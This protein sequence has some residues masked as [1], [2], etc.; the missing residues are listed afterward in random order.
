M[1][2]WLEQNG[3]SKP[4]DL[5]YAFSSYAEAAAA[6]GEEVA[7]LWRRVQGST[8]SLPSAWGAMLK[9]KQARKEVKPPP[10]KAARVPQWSGVKGRKPRKEH[11]EAAEL[12]QEKG[13]PPRRRSSRR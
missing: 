1:S 6:G 5:K 7:E 9:E 8:D 2:D 12:R 10:V 13:R 4:L 3:L 11:S